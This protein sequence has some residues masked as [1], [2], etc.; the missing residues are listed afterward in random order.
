MPSGENHKEKEPSREKHKEKVE[1]SHGSAK[2]HKRKD[3]NKKKIKNVVYYDT[4]TFSLTS[5]NK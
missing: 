2:L 1:E 4:D 5:G 3:G